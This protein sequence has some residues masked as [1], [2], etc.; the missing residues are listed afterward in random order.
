MSSI[1]KNQ[2]PIGAGSTDEYREDGFSSSG[3]IVSSTQRKTAGLILELIDAMRDQC[4]DPELPSQT[5]AMLL[6]I[7]SSSEPRGVVEFGDLVGMSKASASRLVQ[8]LGRGM[9]EKAGL[10][11]VEAYEDPQNWSRKLVKLTPKGVR[12]MGLLEDK[13]LRGLQRLS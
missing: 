12:L 10:G 4:N 7:A 11:L 13:L 8:T 5:M 3:G 2:K 9:R 6:T 1:S